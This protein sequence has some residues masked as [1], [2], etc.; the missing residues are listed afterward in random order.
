MG[1]NWPWCMSHGGDRKH[2][3]REATARSVSLPSALVGR[4]KN[5]SKEHKHVSGCPQNKGGKG[6]SGKGRSEEE[7]ASKQH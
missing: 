4:R 6:G 7:N 5:L 1:E 3:G 2:G